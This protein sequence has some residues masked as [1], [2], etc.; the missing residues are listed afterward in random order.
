MNQAVQNKAL[1]THLFEV[2]LAKRNIHVLDEVCAATFVDHDPGP[3]NP[4]GALE[5][6]KE[7]FRGVFEA[8]PDLKCQFNAMVAENDR[9]GVHVTVTGTHLGAWSGAPATGRHVTHTGFDWFRIQ[10]GKI[11]E[12]WGSWDLAGLF[13]QLGMIPGPNANDLKAISKRYYEILDKTHGDLA[14]LTKDIFHPQHVAIFSNK[15][16]AD[17]ATLQQLIFGFYAGFPDLVHAIEEQICEGDTVFNRLT[18]KGTHKG[19]FAGL[20][21]TGK[22]FA[23]RAVSAH[24]Y[25]DGKLVEQRIEGDFLGLMQQLGVKPS[26]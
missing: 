13:A 17:A 15:P 14:S 20:K 25:A 22:P 9:V 26:P 23:F 8:F 2:G 24:R 4:K 11:T 1:V 12:R 16:Y 3:T 21:P 10:D 7:M 19:E 5:G 6:V 18:V